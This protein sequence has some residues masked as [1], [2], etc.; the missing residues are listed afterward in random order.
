MSDN[1]KLEYTKTYEQEREEQLMVA[2]AESYLESL[3]IKVKIEYG[4]YRNT[5]DILKDFGEYLSKNNKYTLPAE[6][7]I[8]AVKIK[9]SDNEY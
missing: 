4:Y 2:T 3:G 5:W 7:L 8:G 6:Y 1:L 9:E